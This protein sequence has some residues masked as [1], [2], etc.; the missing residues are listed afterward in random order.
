[1]QEHQVAAAKVR[2]EAKSAVDRL[3]TGR[4]GAMSRYHDVLRSVRS[5]VKSGDEPNYRLTDTLT[6][7]R[8]LFKER[9]K[10]AALAPPAGLSRDQ[11]RIVALKNA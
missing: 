6:K 2:S 5:I 8:F 1:M 3:I 11:D 10:V 7:L 4:D 9:R